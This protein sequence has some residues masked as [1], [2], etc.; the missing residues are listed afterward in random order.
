MQG[1]RRLRQCTLVLPH[2]SVAVVH[3]SLA[4]LAVVE[5]QCCECRAVVVEVREMSEAGP[6]EV[7]ATVRRRLQ[8]TVEVEVVQ[9]ET[10]REVV[11]AQL[12]RLA[13]VAAV[14]HCAVT[15]DAAG[16]VRVQLQEA[17]VDARP[18]T[19]T[20]V[21]AAGPLPPHHPSPR[22]HQLPVQVVE[23]VERPSSSQPS[24]AVV[25]EAGSVGWARQPVRSRL[26]V[27]AL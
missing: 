4:L 6:V 16:A 11:G 14:Q 8:S 9:L 1:P 19:T 18:A 12:L 13:A 26:I 24:I 23:A 5:A 15:V 20:A 22:M 7:E 25:E 10:V 21:V 2:A 17:V 27:V 3:S